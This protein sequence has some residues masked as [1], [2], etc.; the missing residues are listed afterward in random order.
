MSRDKQFA[1]TKNQDLYNRFYDIEFNKKLENSV[2]SINKN[3]KVKS[4]E[5]KATES[6]RQ[7]KSKLMI[8]ETTTGKF[9]GD[10]TKD[11]I[12]EL[13]NSHINGFLVTCVKNNLLT[14][15]ADVMLE[16][17][18]AEYHDLVRKIFNK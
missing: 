8:Y 10:I 12:I 13:G 9:I 5:E 7:Y 4:P 18:P 3:G 14:L 17:I 15:Q 2:E 16:L 6:I 1:I 11:E